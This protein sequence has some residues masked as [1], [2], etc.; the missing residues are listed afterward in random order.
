VELSPRR[1]AFFNIQ[2]E[3]DFAM[4]SGTVAKVIHEKGFGFISQENGNDVFFHFKSLDKDLEFSPV[5]LGMRV[6]FSTEISDDGRVRA[7]RVR[8]H[9]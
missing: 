1:R 6:L 3:I 4:Q 8:K 7:S 5:L 2:I 9:Q